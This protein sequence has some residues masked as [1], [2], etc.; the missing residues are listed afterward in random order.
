MA[1]I[2]KVLRTENRGDYALV[3]VQMEDGDETYK[4]YIGGSCEIW[5]AHGTLN[6]FVKKKK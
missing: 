3:Y 1:Q 6:A 4:I 2:R 5:F